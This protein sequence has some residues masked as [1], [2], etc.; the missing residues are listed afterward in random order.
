MYLL[1]QV[2]EMARCVKV[3]ATNLDNLSWIPRIHIM[4]GENQMMSSVV[5]RINK[6][7]WHIHTRNKLIK[8][9][10][11]L[12]KNHLYKHLPLRVKLD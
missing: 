4:V 3:T 1:K 7:S 12:K 10:S 2:R 11:G 8:C 5:I 6:V 9:N